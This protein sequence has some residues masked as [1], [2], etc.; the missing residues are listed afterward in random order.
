MPIKEKIINFVSQFQNGDFAQNYPMNYC[1]PVY[2]T[3]SNDYLPHLKHIIQ[4]KKEKE[5]EKDIDQL[6][7]NFQFVT[8]EEFKDFRKGNFKPKKKIALL[9]FD[10]GYSEF[11]EIVVPMLERKG[12]YAMNFINPAYIDN[13]ELMYRCK[14]SIIIDKMSIISPT[15]MRLFAKNN[16]SEVG[17]EKFEKIVLGISYQNRNQLDKIAE[18]FDINFK[19]YAQKNEP[20]MSLNQL[21]SVTERGF[22]ISNHGFEHPLYHELKLK[23]QLENT[24]KASAF[25]EENKF[26]S[27]SFAFPFTDFKVNEEFFREIFARKNL[28]CTFGSAGLKWDCFE[29]NLQRIPM[30]TG[31]EANQILKEQIAYFKLKKIINRNTIQRK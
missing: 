18:E 11:Y 15:Q 24:E 21:H 31:K 3:V 10:D 7:K 12:I 13:K 5:F 6:T 1:I 9:T 22:G 27:E 2:H 8:W 4:Y 28:F 14:A 17:I 19:D 16:Q 26:I 23:K 25:L 20:Y 29:K 30:E